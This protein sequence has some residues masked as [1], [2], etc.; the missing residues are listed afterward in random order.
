MGHSI[1]YIVVDEKANRKS[2][3][4]DIQEHARRDGDGYDSRMTWHD[5]QPPLATK[6][7][8]E[9]KEQGEGYVAC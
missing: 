1:H 6:E 7:E 5:S 2:V 8:A 4:A 3:M 9:A